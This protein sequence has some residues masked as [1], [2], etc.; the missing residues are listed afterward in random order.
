ML[1]ICHRDVLNRE[2]HNLAM[3]YPEEITSSS[4]DTQ[5]TYYA[6]F[7]APRSYF[8]PWYDNTDVFTKTLENSLA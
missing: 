1:E 4:S 6:S 2:I 7:R 3:K 5:S 8:Q